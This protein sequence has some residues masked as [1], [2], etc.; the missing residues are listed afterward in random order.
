MVKKDFEESNIQL[1]EDQVRQMDHQQFKTLIKKGMRDSAFIHFKEKQAN[2]Q[3]GRFL[4][5]E[6]LTKPQPYLTT[7]KLT[8][9]QIGLLFNLCCQ[10]VWGIRD[11][12]HNLYQDRMCQLCFVE[13]DN[14]KHILLCST[15]M[16]HMKTNSD[17]Q[18]EGI[19]SELQVQIPTYD[20]KYTS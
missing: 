12:F 7:N 18:Y 2:H 13:V 6:D 16:K 3:K 20:E 1:N 8:I 14:Q 9:K 5:H 17:I 4:E 10:S 19:Y 15:L 11:N